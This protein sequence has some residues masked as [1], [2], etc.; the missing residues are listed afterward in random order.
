MDV[1]ELSRIGQVFER[2]GERFLQKILTEAERAAM[3]ARPLAYLASRFA[4]KEAASKALGT[5]FR[6]GIWFTDIEVTAGAFGKPVML[7]AGKARERA[8]EL[9][10]TH[11]HVTLTHGRDVAAA[12]VV[13]EAP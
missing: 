2:H 11:V 1:C 13:L 4:A 10:V 3:P 7:F 5:G 12:V 8:A 6:D 9:G